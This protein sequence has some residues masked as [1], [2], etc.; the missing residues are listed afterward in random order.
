[1]EQR[2]AESLAFPM[3]C[4]TTPAGIRRYVQIPA[5]TL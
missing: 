1:M 5:S 3:G 2:Y 4:N